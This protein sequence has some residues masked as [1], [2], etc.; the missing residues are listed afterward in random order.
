[1]NSFIDGV[2]FTV[3]LLDSQSAQRTYRLDCLRPQSDPAPLAS[4][5]SSACASP[6]PTR[7]IG[8]LT[9]RAQI[10]PAPVDRRGFY[11][12]DGL[13]LGPSLGVAPRT[14]FEQRCL[15][16]NSGLCLLFQAELLFSSAGSRRRGATQFVRWSPRGSQ[17]M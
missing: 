6:S 2:G 3:P 12:E 16:G 4:A 13:K 8:H 5:S 14:G 9:K 17:R 15:I 10:K 7:D 11:R 1:V